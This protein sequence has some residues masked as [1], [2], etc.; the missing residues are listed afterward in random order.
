MLLQKHRLPHSIVEVDIDLKLKWGAPVVTRNAYRVIS[1]PVDSGGFH[2]TILFTTCTW[3]MRP[4][5]YHAV[6]TLYYVLH[7]SES[8][9]KCVQQGLGLML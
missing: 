1:P 6:G 4:V 2:I 5:G 9:R 7:V 8:C 3:G